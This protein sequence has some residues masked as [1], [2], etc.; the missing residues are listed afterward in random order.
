MKAIS[1]MINV[2]TGS[3][4]NK[5]LFESMMSLVV[6]VMEHTDEVGS[7]VRSYRVKFNPVSPSTIEAVIFVGTDLDS[8]SEDLICA[9]VESAI[10]R[11]VEKNSLSNSAQISIN[12]RS[13]R[14]KAA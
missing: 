2:K 6:G 7:N 5:S 9:D 10:E 8:M 3:R 4:V 11:F 13:V 1:L 12:E 14:L